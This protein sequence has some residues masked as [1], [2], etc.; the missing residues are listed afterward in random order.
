MQVLE[1]EL[2]IKKVAGSNL[3]EHFSR[4]V[5]GVLN[6]NEKPIRFVITKTDEEYFYCE[7]DVLI[8]DESYT[9][10]FNQDSIFNFNKR[11]FEK[12]DKFNVVFLIPTGINA[13][14]GGHCGD[15]NAV[16]RLIASACDTL[17][18]HPNVVNASDINEMTENTLYVEGSQLT[19]FMMGQ[20]GLQKVK[21]NRILM[22]MDRHPNSY[23]NEEVVNSV[24]SARI[25]LG[26]D[27]DVFEMSE[28]VDSNSLYSSSG[29]AIG[30]IDKLEL[31]YN[32]IKSKIAN[33]DA[34]ALS[35][36]VKI[37]DETQVAY[38]HDDDIVNPWG[39]IEAM[40]THSV[41]QEFNI[42]S[43]HSPMMTSFEVWNEDVGIVEPRKAPE[44]ASVTY[45]HCILKGLHKSPQ[46]TS[47]EKGI[48]L[49][50]VSCLIIPDG[51][52]GLPVL[53]A[54]QN[55]IP[56]IAVRDNKNEMKNDLTSLPFRKDKLI[57]VNSYLEAVGAMYLIKAGLHIE[58]ITRP[59]SMTTYE[60]DDNFEG[61]PGTDGE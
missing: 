32:T 34:V 20:I 30:S 29:R 36:Y 14:I 48:N 25:S 61:I 22:L 5:L 19:R 4:E 57:I 41:V 44:S 53:S 49:E 3:I 10:S 11:T 9:T 15:G 17:I 46:I 42:P 58:S 47:Y 40:I 1:K 18:T 50:D 12:P 24:S 54:L 31:L 55:N 33:Y 7:I 37:P 28:P 13:E 51:C 60:A 56:V 2:K 8:E 16:S 27:C 23:F 26:I 59:I 43:A 45:L 6:S 21:S 35:T 52:I 38:F 39:G